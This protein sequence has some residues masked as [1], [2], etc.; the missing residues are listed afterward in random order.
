ME[1]FQFTYELRSAGG[2]KASNNMTPEQRQER[3]RAAAKAR[4]ALVAAKR[5]VA[6]KC[7]PPTCEAE[8]PP[9]MTLRECFR[10]AWIIIKERARQGT[11]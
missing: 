11:P 1:K 3:A 8:D 10:L 7:P 9:I 2:T 6:E 4:W 5:L